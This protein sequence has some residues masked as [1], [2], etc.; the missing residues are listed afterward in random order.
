[1]KVVPE[2][3]ALF[4]YTGGTTGTPK[5]AMLTHGNLMAN[6]LQIEAWFTSAEAG[7]EVMLAVLPFFH[8]YG[9][10][11]CMLYGVWGGFEIVML[12]R[13]RPI[14]NVMKVVHKTR[15]SIFP[16]VP[17]LYT[18]INNH[19][20]VKKFDLSSVKICLSGSAPLPQEVQQRFEVLTGGKLVEGYGL[21]E[22]SPVAHAGPIQGFRK[23]GSIGLPLP[24]TDARIVDLET[25]QPLATG[26]VGEL[27]IRGPQVMKGYW[28]R[29]EE[30]ADAL[31]DGWFFTGDIGRMDEDGFFYIV[32]RAKDM[33]AA[34]GLKVLPRDV[35]EVLFTHPAVL[36]AVVAGVPDP[37]RGETVKAWIVLKPG[38]T[39]TAEDITAHCKQDLAA[40]K[41]PKLIEFRTELPKTAVGKVLRRVLVEEE[42]GK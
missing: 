18:A 40:F 26:E 39:A 34:S 15:A 28:Q 11:I 38:A 24:D 32:D 6:M 42:K 1:M 2:D 23:A 30:T 37:Y 5:A 10:T 13:P 41:V 20:D 14:E 22:T 21:S 7:N 16:G 25:K 12:P 27:A 31:R 35:E 4:Q 17:T 9:M 19:P 29:P 8:V 33:I 3:V 36:E